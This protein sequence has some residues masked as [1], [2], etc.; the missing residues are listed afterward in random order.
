MLPLKKTIKKKDKTILHIPES[1][2]PVKFC[3]YQQPEPEF[4][5]RF[6]PKTFNH[7]SALGGHISKAHPGQS[8]A[9]N[10]KKSVRDHRELERELH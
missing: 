4:L 6:C 1:P 8:S 5:C 7:C 10:H 2:N 3:K 9:F